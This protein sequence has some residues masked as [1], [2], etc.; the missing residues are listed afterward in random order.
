M[1]LT[2]L[3]IITGALI[4]TQQVHAALVEN[5]IITGKVKSYDSKTVVLEAKNGNTYEVPLSQIDKKINISKAKEISVT[6]K[7]KPSDLLI[8]NLPMQVSDIKKLKKEQLQSLVLSYQIFMYSLDK[9]MLQEQGYE[10]GNKA[11]EKVT[12][13]FNQFINVAQATTGARCFYAGWPSTRSSSGGCQYP[14]NA[15]VSANITEESLR[16][17]QCGTGGIYRCNPVLFG[18]GSVSPLVA[19][20]S[21]F[22][23]PVPIGDITK[24]ICVEASG[25]DQVVERCTAASRENLDQVVARIRAYPAAFESFTASVT[26]FC[27]IPENSTNA[28]CGNLRERIASIEFDRRPGARIDQ[29]LIAS[30]DNASSGVLGLTAA[31]GGPVCPDALCFVQA[32]CQRRPTEGVTGAAPLPIVAV[33]GCS[34]LG[35]GDDGTAPNVTQ[36]RACILDHSVAS[37]APTVPTD[38]AG[39][40]AG[41][42]EGT[43]Q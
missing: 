38:P 43:V 33:C 29:R 35:S 28:A 30:C 1:M 5:T 21:A 10:K 15:G 34:L 12:W 18:P 40:P 23:I 8:N 22:V 16:Y 41:S 4:S 20:T 42:T 26:Q 37:L 7:I 39:A 17:N 32:N 25:G 9:Q 14:W 24:G 11:T 36:I 6:L 13:L 3:A 2:A 31:P 19:G 27:R